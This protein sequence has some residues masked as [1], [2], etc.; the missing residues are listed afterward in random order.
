MTIVDLMNFMNDAT[1]MNIAALR[2]LPAGDPMQEF[3]SAL[4]DRLPPRLLPEGFFAKAERLRNDLMRGA[5]V[6]GPL[7]RPLIGNP[8]QV[9]ALLYM[10]CGA[11]ADIAGGSEFGARVREVQREHQRMLTEG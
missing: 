3:A 11:L 1:E 4:A 5:A 10:S 9:Y 8:P 7:P 6:D 2:A